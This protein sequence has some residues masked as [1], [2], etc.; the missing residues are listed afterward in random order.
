MTYGAYYTR[1]THATLHCEAWPLHPPGG[2]HTSKTD[3]SS[4]CFDFSFVIFP[5]LQHSGRTPN[6]YLPPSRPS[7][8]ADSTCVRRLANTQ[9]PTSGPDPSGLALYNRATP[10]PCLACRSHKDQLPESHISLTTSTIS[11]TL[12]NRFEHTTHH[13]A[14]NRPRLWTNWTY[15]YRF[16]SS[17]SHERTS[18]IAGTLVYAPP[19]SRP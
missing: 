18:R 8:A 1:D 13:G 5:F 3:P 9:R 15:T 2:T 11:N 14:L 17:C 4:A 6:T 10:K 19:R 16:S 7:L 12:T